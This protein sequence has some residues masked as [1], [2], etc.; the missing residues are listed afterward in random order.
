MTGAGLRLC[1]DRRLKIV[2]LGFGVA[3]EGEG[4]EGAFELNLRSAMP[5]APGHN[6]LEGAAEGVFPSLFSKGGGGSS[7]SSSDTKLI[8]TVFFIDFGG[9]AGRFSSASSSEMVMATA[10][11]DIS[12]IGEESSMKQSF[13]GLTRGIFRKGELALVAKGEI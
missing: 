2:F 12:K 9:G 3:T 13:L 6:V 5:F 11:R 10:R 4:R 7:S 8:V 1:G